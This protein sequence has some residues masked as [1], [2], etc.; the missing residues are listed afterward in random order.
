VIKSEIPNVHVDTFLESHDIIFFE[1][2]CPMKNSY[3][4]SSLPINIIADTSLEPS[5][6]FDHAEH[7]PE[8]IHEEIDS[9]APRR[10]KRSRTAKSFSDDLI[11]Y[12]MDDTHKTIVEAYA[13]PDVDNWKEAVRSEMDSTLF[14]GTWELVDRPY[15]CKSVGCKWMFKKKLRSYGT[16]DKYKVMLVA[17]GYNK[18]EG[19]YFFDT[20]SPVTRL[21]TIYVLLSLTA[22]HDLLIHQM[23]IKI[24]FLNRELEEKIYMTQLDG[25]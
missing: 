6:N 25:L 13:S 2:I 19:E 20:Y 18:K 17:K 16:I 9:E 23:D 4:M 24:A 8:P 11:V 3:D 7:K 12:L 21:T 1:N 22:S 15:G 14:N 10:S 5:E